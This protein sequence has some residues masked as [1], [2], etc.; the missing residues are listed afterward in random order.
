MK[1]IISLLIIILFTFLIGTDAHGGNWPPP[2][3]GPGSGNQGTQRAPVGEG[4]LFMLTLGVAY[5]ARKIYKLGKD[6]EGPNDPSI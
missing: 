4:L 2:P 5:G 1:K 3:P 6:E